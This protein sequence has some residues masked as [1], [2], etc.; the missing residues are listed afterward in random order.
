[1]DNPRANAVAYAFACPNCGGQ[2]NDAGDQPTTRCPY[3][4]NIIPVPEGI[5]QAIQEQQTQKTLSRTMKY[6]LILVIVVFVVPT[7]TGLVATLIGIVTGVTMP[8][9]SILLPY[10]FNH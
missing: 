3:C 9:L 4:Q 5:R 1:M 8:V 7:C 6:I 10:L 2:V